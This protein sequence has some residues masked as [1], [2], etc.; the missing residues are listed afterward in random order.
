M[1]MNDKVYNIF[2]TASVSDVIGRYTEL[3][4][5]FGVNLSA[6]NS[7]LEEAI[8]KFDQIKY[9]YY[10]ERYL[11][12]IST[13]CGIFH[14]AALTEKGSRRLLA[15]LGEMACNWC[16]ADRNAVKIIQKDVSL[17]KYEKGFWEKNKKDILE[18][19]GAVAGLAYTL[20][21]GQNNPAPALYGKEAG[22]SAGEGMSKAETLFNDLQSAITRFNFG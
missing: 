7:C 5:I 15:Y 13:T 9:L 8:I 12:E 21:T 14:K 19:L 6:C 18:G 20:A 10:G 2:N 17:V 3:T 1:K 4:S 16:V 22:K 11:N